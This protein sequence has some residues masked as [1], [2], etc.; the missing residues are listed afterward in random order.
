MLLA[1]K[2]RN[3]IGAMVEHLYLQCMCDQQNIIN[4]RDK[5]IIIFFDAS[6]YLSGALRSTVLQSLKKTDFLTFTTSH[7]NEECISWYE[8]K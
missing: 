1:M 3:V 4:S 8:L 2:T 7:K 6:S 5:Y